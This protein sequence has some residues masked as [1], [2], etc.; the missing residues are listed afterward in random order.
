[1]PLPI[2]PAILVDTTNDKLQ[3]SASLLQPWFNSGESKA[4][5]DLLGKY[6][7]DIVDPKIDSI[8]FPPDNSA[9]WGGITGNVSDQA[10]LQLILDQLEQELAGKYSVTNP[11]GYITAAA[12]I[13]YAPINSPTFTGIVGGITKAMVG[14]GNVDN[15]ADAVKS[16]NYATTAGSA[17]TATSATTALSATNATNATNAVNADNADKVDGYHVAVDTAGTDPNTIYFRTTGGTDPSAAI[18]GDISGSIVDQTDLY[19]ALVTGSYATGNWDINAASVDGYSVQVDGTGSDPNTLYF[20][21][22]GGEPASVDKTY[23][24][25]QATPSA[26]WVVDHNLDKYP[27]VTVLSSTGETVEGNVTYTTSNQATLLFSAQF[28]GEAYFN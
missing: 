4:L 16:V 20:K 23:R 27:S 2:D 6:T 28:A 19:N 3:I 8:V 25:V 17:T 5:L 26:T 13:P 7:N 22:T 24:H 10:D 14:L 1:M 21:T 12:L 18:W 11:S 9:I 15:T